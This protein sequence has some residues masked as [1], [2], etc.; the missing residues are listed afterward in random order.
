MTRAMKNAM[1]MPCCPPMAPPMRT[2][3]AVRT[4]RSSAVLKMFDMRF[5]LHL[6]R[7]PRCSKVSVAKGFLGVKCLDLAR[8]RRY[9]EPVL[10]KN[11]FVCRDLH[12]VAPR[13]V[14]TMI[15]RVSELPDDGLSI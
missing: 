2:S 1:T 12:G 11:S 14:G 4:P 3:M 13:D 8:P 5:G 6:E 9:T 10:G 15:I 7:A